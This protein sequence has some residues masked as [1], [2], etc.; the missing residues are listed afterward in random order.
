MPQYHFE[1]IA[2]ACDTLSVLIYAM[3]TVTQVSVCS[4]KS[5]KEY[6]FSALVNSRIDLDVVCV[7]SSSTLSRRKHQAGRRLAP[8]LEN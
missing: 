4:N 8:P 1:V 6:K 7:S 5:T 3:D 2:S